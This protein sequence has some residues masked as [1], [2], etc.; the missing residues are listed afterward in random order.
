MTR[1][2]LTPTA[3]ARP[4]RQLVMAGSR[5][6]AVTVAA[7]VAFSPLAYA[8]PANPSDAEIAAAQAAVGSSEA[9]V[10]QLA[11]SISAADGQISSIELTIGSLREAVNKALVDLDV[12][13]QAAEQARQE[14][15]SARGDLDATQEEIAKA[16]AALNEISRSQYRRSASGS[17]VGAVSGNATT[18]DALARQTYLRVNA[19]KQREVIATLDRLRT[20]QANNDSRLREARNVAELRAGEAEQARATVQSEMDR[21]NAEL[22]AKLAEHA[23]LIA[24]RLEAQR[25]LDAARGQVTELE[26]QRTEYEQYLAAEEARKKA[27]EEARKKAEEARRAAEAAAAAQRAAEEKAAKEAAE[28]A[29]REAEAA[30]AREEQARRESVAAAEAL[31]SATTTAPQ[32]QTPA[33]TP[34]SEPTTAE[35]AEDDL[36]V[37]LEDAA[38]AA[39]ATGTESSV[40]P[41]ESASAPATSAASASASTPAVTSGNREE[42]IEAVISRAMAQIGTPYAWGGGDANGPTRGIRDGGV[43]DSYGDFNKVGFD[44]SGLV[45]YA[46]AG[47]GIELPHYTGYQYQRGTKINPSEMQRGDL[48]FYGPN[49]EQHVAIYLGDGQMLEAPNSG[50]TVRISPV[51]WSGM[52]PYAVRLI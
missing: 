2:A 6:A 52:S 25:E 46:F 3:A 44:C 22:E 23:A 34:A 20:E 31:V 13:Q 48:I 51:R 14:V 17:G 15:T 9:S 41:S 18:E 7:A 10:A 21:S 40:I 50:S 28:Q 19:D 27:E 36:Y 1:L 42:K 5:I 29:A 47:V 37:T 8:Q 43:A 39:G 26:N 11:T 35:Q 32:A 16:Q 30:A 49:A 38:G 24:Q 45:L 4:T 33:E 12:A